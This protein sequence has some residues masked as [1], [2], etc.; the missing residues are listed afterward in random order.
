MRTVRLGELVDSVGGGTPAKSRVEFYGGNIPW[1]TPKDMKVPE[2]SDSQVRITEAGL[3]HSSA[4]LV[5]SGSVLLVTRSGVLKHTLPVAITTVPV[6][7]NQD[8]RALLPGPRIDFRYLAHFLRA[9]APVVL[10]WVRATTADNFPFSRLLDLPVSLPPLEDQHRIVQALDTALAI[11]ERRLAGLALLD[12][13]S[14]SDFLERFGDAL[15]NPQGWPLVPL[16][17]LFSEP[18]TYGTMIPGHAEDGRWLCLRVANISGWQLDLSDRKFVDL[19]EKDVRRH[20]VREG[21]LLLARAIASQAHLG[22]A[23][24]VG[25]HQQPYAFDSHL[26]RLRFDPTRAEPLFI[27]ALLQSSGGRARFMKVTRRSA[28]QFNVNTKEI[29]RLTIPCPPLSLQSEFVKQQLAS[30]R[31]RTHAKA[32]LREINALFASLQHRAFT[33]AL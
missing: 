8:M 22:K 31:T 3:L 18:P 12:H 1:V 25:P 4:R 24:V 17:D 26:M 28:V 23:I 30:N 13:L 11:R 32:H 21:D 9:K 5:P 20:E 14:A 19:P 7:L 10:R 27:R 16:A 15:H 29:S 33:G 6:S 2:I